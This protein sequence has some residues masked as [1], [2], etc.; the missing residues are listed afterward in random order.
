[1]R[2]TRCNGEHLIALTASEASRLVDACALLV[3]ASEASP[4]AA[5]PPDMATLLGQL[6][7]GLKSAT[8]SAKPAPKPPC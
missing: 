1:M 7:D 6:F 4:Q 8:Q 3:L 5:L 2:I